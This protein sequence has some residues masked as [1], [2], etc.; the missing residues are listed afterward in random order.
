M[1]NVKVVHLLICLHCKKELE[2]SE[3]EMKLRQVDCWLCG[4]SNEFNDSRVEVYD[5]LRTKDIFD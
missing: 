2:I 3:L 1:N 4:Y 5:E